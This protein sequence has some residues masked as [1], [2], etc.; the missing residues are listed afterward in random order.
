MPVATKRVHYG[1]V[2]VAACT[3]ITTFTYGVQYSFGVFLDPLKKDFE[4]SSFMISWVP[5]LY[6][7]FICV[8]GLVAGWLT[9]RYSPR[10]I[11]GVGGFF[12][13]LGLVLTS[14]LTAPW[15]IFIYYSFMVG[16]GT[17]CAGPPIFTTVARWIER[18]RGLALGIVTTGIAL[19]TMI[20]GP[21]A[22]WLIHSVYDDD[23]R[24]PCRIIGFLA[25]LIVAAGLLL[26]KQPETAL[27][28]DDME[29]MEGTVY[30]EP[31]GLNLG[32]AL[33][34]RA[35]WLLFV[36]HVL[37]FAGLLLVMYHVV[38]YAKET[39]IDPMA[40]A[41]LLTV[42]GGASIGGRL[43]GGIT[44]DSVGR[45]PIFIVCL[46]LQGA[47]MIWLSEAAE[48]PS[49]GVFYTAAA[50]WGVGYGGWAPLM[51]ALTAELFGLRHMGSILGV[52]AM[53]YGIGGILGP[54]IAGST[55]TEVDSYSTAFMIGAGIMF[56][57]ALLVPF[58]KQPG[59]AS[60]AAADVGQH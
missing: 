53:S 56:L 19:G 21:L 49:V 5:G 13:G 50:F 2:I 25:W 35:L 22:E 11:V 34:T 48:S 51:S 3:I 30:I 15:Q 27:K 41:T 44:S 20:I 6:M 39:D 40:A 59:M 33:R 37:A 10:V 17:G 18:H 9:D 8:F 60:H 52:V 54:A 23:W 7:F 58:L 38:T 43:V 31:G 36:I 29:G 26:R 12:I 46:L 42:I 55:H 32:Q 4:W 57:A 1:W 45:K 28:Q 16:F 47:M 24:M 14:L